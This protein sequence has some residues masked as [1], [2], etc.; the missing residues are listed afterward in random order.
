MFQ[1]SFLR[2]EINSSLF[3]NFSNICIY[4]Q[5]FRFNRRIV[6]FA[7]ITH[8]FR[9]VISNEIIARGIEGRRS[10]RENWI[11][12]FYEKF[13]ERRRTRRVWS[14]INFHLS[15]LVPTQT[16][17]KLGLCVPPS[18]SKLLSSSQYLVELC[19]FQ[20]ISSW[21]QVCTNIYLFIST[22]VWNN[23]S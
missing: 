22:Y 1:F 5:F 11:S 16:Y 4:H 17:T 6:S 8:T 10:G 21:D 3:T 9:I 2:R 7:R 15:F 23:I 13:I 19:L 12:E 20:R 14:R 18:L